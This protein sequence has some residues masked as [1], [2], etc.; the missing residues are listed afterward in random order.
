MNN[1]QLFPLLLCLP[2]VIALFFWD[3]DAG[4]Q[5]VEPAATGDLATQQLPGTIIENTRMTQYDL[6][7][8]SV[9]NLQSVRLVSSEYQEQVEAEAPIITVE[10]EDGTWVGRSQH[11]TFDRRNNL[12]IMQGDVRLTQQGDREPVQMH[13]ERLDYYP[14]QQLATTGE[15]VKVTTKGHYLESLGVSIDLANSIYRLPKRVRSTHVLK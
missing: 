2:I 1:R 13:T 12:L 10:N 15:L 8:V 9:H 6:N 4:L 14:D 3:L 11:G 5:S 7:G